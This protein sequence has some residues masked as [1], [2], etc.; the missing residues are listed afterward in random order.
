M[1]IA[2]VFPNGVG[3]VYIER[4]LPFVEIQLYFEIVVEQMKV[5]VF[6]T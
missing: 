6:V 2:H 1:L 3:Y 5:E 4:K